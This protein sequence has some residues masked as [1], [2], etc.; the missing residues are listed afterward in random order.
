MTSTSY[1]PK[2]IDNADFKSIAI[3]PSEKMYYGRYAYKLDFNSEG[4]D[5]RRNLLSFRRQIEDFE[6]DCLENFCRPYIARNGIRLYFF[7]YS[8]LLT[9][10]HVFK[11]QITKVSGPIN[12][13]HL[14]LLLSKD[15]HV[16]VRSQ[17]WFKKYDC[18]VYLTAKMFSN[19]NF[20]RSLISLDREKY[21]DLIQ[22]QQDFFETNLTNIKKKYSWDNQWNEFYCDYAEFVET[23]PFLRLQHPDARLIV[24]KV[25]LNDKYSKGDTHGQNTQ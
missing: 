7:N 16:Q 14:D 20:Y 18:K 8:D 5:T 1:R 9:T 24:Y 22:G 19:G 2:L 23:L 12:S 25:V 15:Y 6:F 3:F 10:Y 11:S 13:E 17:N 21:K 4:I